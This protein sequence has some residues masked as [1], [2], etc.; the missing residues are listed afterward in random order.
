MTRHLIH[1]GYPKTGSTFLQR[2]F[3]FHPELAYLHGRIAGSDNIY[4]FVGS[5]FDATPKAWRVTSSEAISVPNPHNGIPPAHRSDHQP[6]PKV[7]AAQRRTCEMLTELF[8]SAYI[9]IVTRGFR[10]MALSG[11]SQYVRIGG[12][13]SLED[14][15][16]RPYL[17]TYEWNYDELIRQYR[18]AFPDRVIVM[19]YEL[20]AEDSD[21]FLRV[22]EEKMGIAHHDFRRDRVN[23]TLSPVELRWYPRIAR[24]IA[25]VTG[26]RN[27]LWRIYARLVFTNRLRVPIRLANRLWPAP[28]LD[29]TS[30]PDEIL[31]PLGALAKDLVNEPLYARYRADYQN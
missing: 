10:G 5:S 19:P 28:P 8:P 13:Y 21:A 25:S 4:S 18:A 26:H 17:G 14:T 3:E 7:A 30:I 31:R 29:G 6:W 24:R 20:L 1:I 27:R 23:A 11:Y 15:L 9:L 12:D 2:W 22:L 16:R